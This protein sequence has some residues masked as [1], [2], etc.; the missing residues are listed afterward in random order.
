[1]AQPHHIYASL[2]QKYMPPRTLRSSTMTL[3]AVP[4]AP[5]TKT[6][7]HRAFAIHAPALWNSIPEKLRKI[8]DF[9]SFKRAMK[10][11]LFRE[12]FY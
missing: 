11:F 1:M 2:F 9:K 3:V 8:N 4:K 10:T 12:Y 5:N 6:Y 7:G